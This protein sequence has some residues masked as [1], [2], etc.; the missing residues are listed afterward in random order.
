MTVGDL[1]RA[2]DPETVLQAGS[3]LQRRT[4]GTDTYNSLE[5]A[6]TSLGAPSGSA[7]SIERIRT[8]I[9][10]A[11]GP[12]NL[13]QMADQAWAA[14]VSG[15]GRK[16]ADIERRA[17]TAR[18]DFDEAN[19]DANSAKQKLN[20]FDALNVDIECASNRP[21][22]VFASNDAKES[23]AEVTQR[24]KVLDDERRGV[25]SAAAHSISD[26]R[27]Q[28]VSARN[29]MPNPPTISAG[30]RVSARMP[31]GTTVEM[32]AVD[33]AQLKDPA[34][35]GGVWATLPPAERQRRVYR[36]TVVRHRSALMRPWVSGRSDR[37]G[38]AQASRSRAA[39]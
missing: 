30:V 13:V 8:L 31:D 35:I 34:T 7:L 32:S 5:S 4:V 28:Y 14:E 6:Q 25:D 9:G 2:G 20:D 1:A 26:Q 18:S 11:S 16:M 27:Q 29:V 3:T 23:L 24:L 39:R 19:R 37:L 36:S 22:L 21:T 17:I 10:A 33:L 12:A 38:P 15:F